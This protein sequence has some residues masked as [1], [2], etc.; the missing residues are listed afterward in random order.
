MSVLFAVL[1]GLLFVGSLAFFAVSYAWG[2]DGV[3]AWTAANGWPPAAIDVV[4]FTVFALHH[5]VFARTPVRRSL[6][7]LVPAE[8]ERSVYV[9]IAS[10]L[11]VIVCAFWQ[12]VPGALWDVSGAARWLMRGAQVLGA[13]LSVISAR[14]LDVLALAGVRQALAH[15]TSP[16][17]VGG[18]DPVLDRG[19][20][21]IVRHPIYFGWFLM[22]WCTPQMN[23]TRL[24]FAAIS[25]LY[26]VLAIPFEERDL[27][28]TFGPSYG[29][30]SERVR[31]RIV[32]GV[33]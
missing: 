22:V 26:L 1:G 20:Y 8:L 5:S 25:C 6:E 31:W 7:R 29:R 19:P 16:T 21:G 12:P 33:Y 2:F 30:Y 27:R 18:G 3:T 24:V 9:W 13:V 15:E 17:P 14:R 32:P 10:L 23:G 28:Q 11:F 4:L